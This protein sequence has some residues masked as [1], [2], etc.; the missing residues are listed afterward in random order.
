MDEY[1]VRYRSIIVRFGDFIKEYEDSISN[2]FDKVNFNCRLRDESATFGARKGVY[3]E[4]DNIEKFPN[5]AKYEQ[6][7]GL[8]RFRWVILRCKWDVTSLRN[9]M[10]CLLRPFTT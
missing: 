7:V 8:S 2:I 1:R 6:M 5:L 9:A 3:F 10:N 4:K